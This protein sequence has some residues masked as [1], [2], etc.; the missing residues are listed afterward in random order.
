MDHSFGPL[1]NATPIYYFEAHAL[2][3]PPACV[4]FEGSNYLPGLWPEALAQTSPEQASL[5]DVQFL[6]RVG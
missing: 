2:L 3:I 5:N 1:F 6:W 4:L